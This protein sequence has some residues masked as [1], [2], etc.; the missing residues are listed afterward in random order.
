MPAK[1]AP[2]GPAWHALT[3]DAALRALAGGPDG[4]TADE[5]ARRLAREGPNRL[6]FAPPRGAL[7]RFLDQFDNL[8]IYVLLAAAG[9]TAAIGHW[10]DSG[11]I[12]GVVVINAL[13]GFVQE[14]RAEQAL[15]AIRRL[16]AR[17]ARVR[18]DG[19]VEEIDAAGLVPGDIAVI[20]AG[21]RVPADLRLLECHGLEIDESTL[22]GESVPVA[23]DSRPVAA[24]AP[25]AERRS[26]AYSGT[27]VTKG[28]ATGLAIATGARSEV[29]RIGRL[30]ETVAPASTPLLD[31]MARFNR[32]LTAAIV[33]AAAVLVAIGT[34]ARDMPLAD[35]F[36][37][38]VGFAVAAIPEGLPAIM[39]IALAVGV[40]RMARRHAIVRH[41]PAIETLGA[42]S[43][44]CTDKTGTLT[45]NEMTVRSLALNGEILNVTGSGY[46]PE[47]RIL[48][49]GIAL[50][51]DREP[52]LA[53]LIEAG[54][55]C[56]SAELIRED[57]ASSAA[58]DG[59]R[60]NGDPLEAALLVLAA[61]AGIDAAAR[62]A[63]LPRADLLPFDAEARLMATLHRVAAGGYLAV[64]KGA[65]EAVLPLC[66]DAPAGATAAVEEMAR[67]GE[68]VIALA[69]RRIAG[70]RPDAWTDFA[71][72]LELRGLCG[73]SDPPRPEAIA[74]VRRCRDAGIRVK[75][76]TGDHAETARAI[77]REFAFDDEGGA[78][79]GAHLD[80]L[81]DTAFDRAARDIDIF[82]RIDPRQKLRLVESLRR[83][84][85]IAAMTGDGV[86]D[87]PA[88]RQA[89]VGVAM[90]RKGT[91]AAKE[92][93]QI[94]LSDDNF[95][96]IAAA[97]EE[98]RVVH[99]NLRKAIGY[100]LPTS[101]GEALIIVAAVL[102]GVAL[103]ITPV[104]ILWVNLVTEITLSLALAFE[105]AE[106]DVMARPPRRRQARLLSP[107]LGWRVALVTV[108]IVVGTFWQFRAALD[109]GATLAE[110]RTVAVNLVVLFEVFYLINARSLSAPG[111]RFASWAHALPMAV[112]ILIVMLLQLAL[113]YQPAMNALFGTAPLTA[114]TWG[115][116]AAVAASVFVVA[117]IERFV[118]SFLRRNVRGDVGHDARQYE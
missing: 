101:I 108:V 88:L 37:A 86:N 89:D 51:I 27:L 111:W 76:I 58:G 15:A 94:V 67:R 18:R 90:G 52:A 20:E 71:G 43:I 98:G 17:R 46:A 87:A 95:A 3:G 78:I 53:K 10:T 16:L 56:N 33:G 21:D 116:M 19:R 35:A 44:I 28:Q 8:L 75:M 100:I 115:K 62:R 106:P 82:A 69:A 61:K 68:R 13:I 85:F 39:T 72:A 41:L 34:M 47:G 65:P 50:E 55:L 6:E 9:I 91:E 42:V 38:A 73:L 25:V 54:L 60:V 49:D 112:A 97:V 79:A 29:G 96:S 66:R 12:A 4:L 107:A 99:D 45:R 22:T 64:V 114:A 110:A 23:K 36:L 70:D 74:A 109:Q 63:A 11:V 57:A 118:L 81:D 105:K 80:K 14:Q 2:N 104:L 113:T 26:L 84:G 59:W 7:R 24:D 92:A 77:A 1:D 40:R 83:Q 30:V 32:W 93:S 102:F 48:R 5:A 103:P 117:E 31:Q